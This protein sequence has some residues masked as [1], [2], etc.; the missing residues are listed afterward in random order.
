MSYTIAQVAKIIGAP[1]D[2]ARGYDTAALNT[3]IDWLLTDSRSLA[4]P[5]TSLFFALVTTLQK[6]KESYIK[7]NLLE[8]ENSLP[9]NNH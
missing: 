3:Q 7:L 6:L 9:D 4:F 8:N 5:E 1:L 2:D